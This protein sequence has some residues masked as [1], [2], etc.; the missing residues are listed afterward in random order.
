MS[1]IWCVT[2]PG[3]CGKLFKTHWKNLKYVIYSHISL[4]WKPEI[5]LHLSNNYHYNNNKT[6]YIDYTLHATGRFVLNFLLHFRK[7]VDNVIVL[8]PGQPEKPMGVVFVCI[9]D[10][11]GYGLFHPDS[12]AESSQS[13]V[14]VKQT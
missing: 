10:R 2:M 11:H 3:P 12:A 14:S 8:I 6:M 13:E 4:Q 5:M 7:L 9:S 1:L